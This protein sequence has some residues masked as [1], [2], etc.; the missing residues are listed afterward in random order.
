MSQPNS[1][2]QVL[3]QDPV[4]FLDYLEKFRIDVT[5]DVDSAGSM[6]EAGKKLGRVANTYA[7]LVSLYN[8]ANMLKRHLSRNGKTPEYQEMIDKENALEYTLRAMDMQYK[9]LSKAITV[10]IENNRELYYTDG[11][12]VPQGRGGTRRK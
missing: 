9:A 2:L 8:Y 6:D 12:S 4:S 7:Y 11:V 1:H 3:Q 5:C 10:H